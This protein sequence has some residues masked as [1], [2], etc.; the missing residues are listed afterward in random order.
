MDD[1]DL[2]AP[3]SLGRDGR[4]KTNNVLIEQFDGRVPRGDSG[5]RIVQ[6][7][8]RTS[9][10]GHG[11]SRRTWQ[12]GSSQEWRR[13][14]DTHERAA[15]HH[16]LPSPGLRW[17]LHLPACSAGHLQVPF[18]FA[19]R[20]RIALSPASATAC[21][22]RGLIENDSSPPQPQ[23]STKSRHEECLAV[24]AHGSVTEAGMMWPDGDGGRRL[25]SPIPSSEHRHST[26]IPYP[27]ALM[28][29]ESA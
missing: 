12:A 13:E 17:F 6:I 1:E 29:E 8:W 10:I 2:G 20:F 5:K 23:A 18:F 27:S 14:G 24:F 15:N 7:G 26:R 28:A 19:V 4:V 3:E 22:D 9:A 16:I 11:G 21:D 25:I